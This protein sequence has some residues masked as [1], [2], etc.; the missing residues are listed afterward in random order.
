LWDLSTIFAGADLRQ[1][2]LRGIPWLLVMEITLQ[3]GVNV[4]DI[5]WDQ[6]CEGMPD[7]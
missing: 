4:A 7:S 6:D 2:D 1:A 3:P 5:L